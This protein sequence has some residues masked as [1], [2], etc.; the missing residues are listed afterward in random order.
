MS[1][2]GRNAFS[3]QL[4]R[5]RIADG[6]DQGIELLLGHS[7]RQGAGRLGLSTRSRD[8]KKERGDKERAKGNHDGTSSQDRDFRR[9][10][11][12]VHHLLATRPSFICISSRLPPSLSTAHLKAEIARTTAPRAL[13]D[14]G[15]QGPGLLRCPAAR[16]SVRNVNDDPSALAPT[17][18]IDSTSAKA[19]ATA[20]Q[21]WRQRHRSSRPRSSRCQSRAAIPRAG[22]CNDAG[23]ARE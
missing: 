16:R 10:A 17:L 18:R 20:G 13:P 5:N 9:K 14:P 12:P 8:Q 7:R 15:F 1:R 21:P 11:R 19:T 3:F 6:I 22:A 23:C 2:R 4:F